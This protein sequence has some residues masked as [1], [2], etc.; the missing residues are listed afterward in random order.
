MRWC[1]AA[2]RDVLRRWATG[3][4]IAAL[5]VVAGMPGGINSI[6]AS[7][8]AMCAW[9]V[10]P[11]FHAASHPG[12][13]VSA[14]ILQA[15]FGATP[16]W[17]MRPLLWSPRWA[18]AERSLPI[19]P[20]ELLLSDLTVATL[21]LLPLALLYGVGAH[22]VHRSGRTPLVAL[23]VAF[24]GSVLA[25]LAMLQRL[26]AAP[27]RRARAGGGPRADH[28]SGR[29]L[30]R[31]RPEERRVGWR[32]AVLW[33]PLWRGPAR[34]SGR[35]LCIGTAAA[36]AI[37]LIPLARPAA[38]G[39]WLAAYALLSLSL[40]I[41]LNALAQAELDPLLRACS[42]LP[43]PVHTMLRTR[44][45]ST[46]LPLLPSSL[47]LPMGL[48]HQAIRP[49]ALASYLLACAVGWIAELA[50]DSGNAA[51]ATSRRL[52]CIALSVALAFEV[53]K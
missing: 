48:A 9:T 32:I 40:V 15:L 46:L 10:L 17:V 13:I 20:S 16:L 42:P 37:D 27:N 45:W 39:G 26:R 30:R 7:V 12:W 11:L 5:I 33:W 6:E 47:A 38:T 24:T 50:W 28:G 25:G 51:H 22:A 4:S 44:R 43:L 2:L 29:D 21:A 8:Q 34:R 52:F 35:L 23:S 3:F 14:T 41:G 53:M 19:R 31:T 49:W 18:V 36:C 1:G